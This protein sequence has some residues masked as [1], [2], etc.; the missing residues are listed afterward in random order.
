VVNV[1]SQGARAAAE[2]ETVLGHEDLDRLLPQNSR[3]AGS[4]RR[5]AALAGDNFGCPIRV[6]RWVSSGGWGTGK[7][8]LMEAVQSELQD[9]EQDPSPSNF[10]CLA[11]RARA[12]CCSFRCST[13]SG[14]RFVDRVAR[15]RSQ[16][17][18][19]VRAR[20]KRIGNGGR[21]PWAAGF[22]GVCRHTRSSNHK[23]ID[24]GSATDAVKKLSDEDE[25]IGPAGRL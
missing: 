1:R 11:V 15:D 9:G 6:S 22:S 19:L 4:R 10:K 24:V 5:P 16:E 12:G 18:K 3:R 8:T 25:G 7:T 2:G 17:Q 23:L 21:R 13:K 20:P 14:Q